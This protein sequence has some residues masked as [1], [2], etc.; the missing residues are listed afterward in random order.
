MSFRD[1]TGSRFSR[2]VVVDVAEVKHGHR[3]WNVRCDCGN[4]RTV[5]SQN[6]V[7]GGSKSCG[8]LKDEKTSVRFSSHRL[9]HTAEYRVWHGMLARCFN[10]NATN[11]KIYGGRGIFVCERWRD[12]ANFI[13]DMGPRPSKDHSIDRINNDGHYSPENCRWSTRTEQWQN[14]R[15][16]RY[17]EH[18]GERLC[19]KEWAKRTRLGRATIASRIKQGWTVADALTRPAWARSG[20]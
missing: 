1:L 18:A 3:H 12:F 14:S 6:L 4:V 15:V 11:F 2:W 5:S 9:S 20:K 17:L 8:C 19:V 13:A 7:S 10:P 16:P